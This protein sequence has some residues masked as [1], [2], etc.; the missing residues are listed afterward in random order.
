VT[1]RGT[2]ERF[3]VAGRMTVSA[4]RREENP[5]SF[6][7]TYAYLK[8]R[9]GGVSRRRLVEANHTGIFLDYPFWEGHGSSEESPGDEREHSLG[10]IEN[11]WWDVFAGISLTMLR[12]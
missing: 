9:A 12:R 1:E 3:P 10:E 8:V 7:L 11:A 5:S 2:V 6:R 4:D